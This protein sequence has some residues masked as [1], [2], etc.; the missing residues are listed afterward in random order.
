[1]VLGKYFDSINGKK[2]YEVY[3]QPTSIHAQLFLYSYLVMG[4]VGGICMTVINFT[5]S[6]GKCFH[7]VCLFKYTKQYKWI[8]I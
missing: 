2:I 7:G 6:L 4:N 1:M 8:P 3:R 5:L